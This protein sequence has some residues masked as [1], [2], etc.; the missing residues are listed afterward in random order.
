MEF[1]ISLV[2]F[3]LFLFMLLLFARMIFGFVMA[4]QRGWRPTGALLL[5]TEGVFTATDPP[6]K[7][8]RKVV[9]PLSLG[10]IRLDLAF[11][12]LFFSCSMLYQILGVYG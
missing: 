4:F 2:R 5:I 12:I 7:A 3:A 9:P 11:L 6:L 8:I 1:L 10:T